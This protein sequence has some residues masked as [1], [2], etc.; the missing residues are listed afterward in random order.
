MF[1]ALL[2]MLLAYFWSGVALVILAAA[3]FVSLVRLMLPGIGEYRSE[4]ESWVSQYMAQPVEIDR[5]QATWRGWTPHLHLQG[6]RLL[7]TTKTRTLTHFEQ[8]DV[9]VDIF[10]SVL[11]RALVPGQVT[12]SGVELT[13]LRSPNGA[14]TIEGVAPEQA[15]LPS[16]RQNA[17]AYWLQ[18]QKN[19]AIQ[20]AKIIWHDR[21]SLLRPVVFSDVSLRI[22]TDGERRQLEGSAHLPEE[23]GEKFNFLLDVQGDL[24]TKNWSGDI[25]IEGQGIDPPGM[26]DYSQWLGL[27]LD[28]GLLGFHLWSRWENARL[29]SIDG[30]VDLDGVEIGV[31][32]YRFELTRASGNLH[33]Q[34]D[35]QGHWL[36]SLDKLDVTTGNG[37]WPQSDFSLALINTAAAEPTS[38]IARASFL[39]LND[40]APLI[41][42]IAVLPESIRSAVATM[43]PGGELRDLRIG[44]FADRPLAQRFY[45]RAEFG[46]IAT[47]AFKGLPGVQGL[48]G[49]VKADADGGSIQ[50]SSSKLRLDFGERIEEELEFGT[51]TGDLAWAP[52]EAGWTVTVEA[53]RATSEALDAELSGAAHWQPDTSPIINMIAN[54]Q[55]GNLEQLPRLVPKGVL[56]ARGYDWIQRAINGGQLTS[57]IVVVRGP[58]EHFPFDN[59]EGVFKARFTVEDLLLD[60]HPLWPRLEEVEAELLFQGREFITNAASGK[61][62]NL[63]FLEVHTR[64]PDLTI[65]KRVVEATGKLKFK[66]EDARAVIDASPLSLTL[67]RRLA[68]LD[69]SGPMQLDLDLLVPLPRGSKPLASGILSID[70]T[71]LQSQ[72]LP[73]NLQA[74]KGEL[75]FKGKHWNIEQMTGTYLD[76]PV[77]LT[78]RGQPD[79]DGSRD[80][81][82]LTG[83]AK[84]EL[85]HKQ[86]Q[87]LAPAVTDWLQARELF[88][89]LEGE[90]DWTTTLKTHTRLKHAPERI[91][92]VESALDGMEVGLPN[93]LGK[94]QQEKRSLRISAGPLSKQ[95]SNISFQYGDSMRGRVITQ[96]DEANRKHLHGASLVFGNSSIGPEATPEGLTMVGH[97]PQLSLERWITRL[98]H[99]VSEKKS[100]DSV[101]PTIATTFDVTIDSLEA[102]GFEFSDVE[103]QA[104][105]GVDRWQIYLAGPLLSGK[106]EVPFALD[107]TVVTADF[108]YLNLVSPESRMARLNVDPSELPALMIECD[109]FQ[110]NNVDLGKMRLSS[111]PVSNGV[112]IE[113]LSF[114]NEDAKSE[115]KGDWQRIDGVHHSQFDINVQGQDLGL[116]LANFGYAGAAIAGGTT[117]IQIF[118]EWPG[119]PADFKLENLRGD[120]HIGVDDG[121]LLDVDPKAGRLFGLLSMQTLPRRLTLDFND[122]FKKGFSF[123][124]IE[125]VFEL[126]HGHAYTNNLSMA[127]PAARIEITGRTGLADQD[128][129]Q[130]V[131]VT[132]QLSNSLPLAGAFFGPAGAGVGAVLFLGQKMFK[133]LPNQIDNM[134]SRQYSITG[135]WDEPVVQRIKK[136][137]GVGS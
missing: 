72:E 114:T 76:T 107:N 62:L 14:V 105:S 128:Y 106:I 51:V 8:A 132:P 23:I 33:A 73:I 27:R 79:E 136:R 127:G 115:A 46:G 45:L 10:T 91:V 120:M 112:E 47:K 104:S 32:D 116:L 92:T 89:S 26:L 6:I 101:A 102:F 95:E 2:K 67:G 50:L 21:Q 109:K 135:N 30:K 1:K 16:V 124:R 121:R 63:D 66:A 59:S 61:M 38:L 113:S 35:M 87:K 40:I 49:T 58:L 19:L 37:A 88:D 48:S 9:S 108:D 85:I 74:L 80:E 54:V 126:D 17:L 5:I 93:P 94:S 64:I 69:I 129:D 137:A 75:Q 42:N 53:L 123:D 71:E 83:K 119:A 134:L 68:N 98:R 28:K 13:L 41:P 20:S 36:L 133:S 82:T 24:L 84:P 100:V 25:Y 111:R 122:L 131:T 22:R 77:S 103:L 3:V 130:L 11:R 118:A 78:G 4:I 117:E 65:K 44:Y 90:T 18:N 57:G 56:P 15:G 7:D 60:F 96:R 99:G 29:V 86:M 110:F 70:D 12:V 43:Q 52:S 125:G 39:R 81:F 55:R 97:L 31:D 34:R